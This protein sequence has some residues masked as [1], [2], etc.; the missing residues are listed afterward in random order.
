VGQSASAA[1]STGPV[2]AGIHVN[3]VD[4]LSAD[5]INGVDVSSMIAEEASGV[6]F[7][8]Q[9]GNVADLFDVLADAGVTTVR[10]RVWNDPYDADGNGY[11]GGTNDVAAA[12]EMG[13]RATAAGL[14]V[15]V[16]FHY[17]DFWAD[18]GKQRS[19]KAWE[20]LAI[21]DR[22]DAVES[23][24]ADVLQQ[25]K[26][27]GV[28]VSMVQV[29]NETNSG[30][31]GVT[32]WD[33]MAAIFSAGSAAVRTVFPSA[34][35]V[36]HFTNPETVGRYAG[37]AAELD[38]RGVDY[39][40]FASSYYPYW[41]GSLSHLTSVLS[42]VAATY[43][44]EVMV[45]E[46]SWAYTLE[47]GDGHENTIKAASDA[48]QYPVSV[49]GQATAV[50]DVIQAVSDV[51]DGKG[52]GV[53]Y[54]EPAWIPV[55]PASEL[56]AN[57]VLW[58]ADGSGWA[59]SFAGD[60]DADASTWYGGSSWDNQA[61]FDFAGNPLE[62]LNVFSY[63]RTGAVAPLEVTGVETVTL[64]VTAG[65][66]IAL[67]ATVT[68]SY[69]DSTTAQQAVTWSDA[70]TWI[71]GPGV[72]T[73]SGITSGGYAT[74]ATITVSAPSSLV[75]GDFETGDVTPW[76]LTATTW[77]STF[78]IG[79]SAGNNANGTYAIN[80]YGSSAF[81]FNLAQ[82]VTGLAPGDYVLTG[83]VH[84]QDAAPTDAAMS[85]FA[86]TSAGT[87]TVLYALN[88]WQ[89]WSTPQI[90]VTVPAD[91]AVTVGASG[92]GG[93]ADWAWFDDFSLV[94]YEAAVVDTSALEA[95]LAVAE[96]ISRA[97]YTPESL[98]VLDG[99]IEIAH[100][101]LGASAPVQALVDD[102]VGV[103]DGAFATLVLVGDAPDPT[104]VPVTLTVVEGGTISLPAQ[105]TVK[106][107]NGSATLEGVTWSNSATWIGGPGVYTVTGITS[108]GWQATA[109]VT[110]TVKNWLVNGDFETGDPAP[111]SLTA[112]A[113]PATFWTAS[114][115]GNS[116]HGTWAVSYYSSAG[117]DLNL[118]QTVS[119]LPEGA[120]QFSGQA[121]GEDVGTADT[122][123]TLVGASSTDSQNAAFVLAGWQ[124]WNSQSVAVQVGP[125]GTFTASVEGVGGAEDWGWIDDLTL[126]RVSS[127]AVDTLA[128]ETLLAQ[129]E[130]ADTS[131]A[132]ASAMA[133]LAEAIEAAHVVLAATRP[134]QPAIDGVTA[135]LQSAIDGLAPAVPASVTLSA[136]T[137][138][139]GST[140]TVQIAGV[141]ES[142]V[143]VGVASRFIRLATVTLDG[144]SGTAVITIPS[145]LRPGVHYVQVRNLAGDVL[146]QEA[147]TVLAG[148]G[149]P[150]AHHPGWGW[151]GREHCS[152][153]Q[154]HH[155]GVEVASWGSD[156]RNWGALRTRS[157]R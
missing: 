83:S 57:K 124:V 3:K 26:D 53:F 32:G 80:A 50:R 155:P 1:D 129:A 40:V 117:F 118:S 92:V 125:D 153:Y 62:S 84:G 144:G 141:N 113:W 37:Y 17:S 12:V 152:P 21:G 93:A 114:S 107:Y 94:P 74:S 86:T 146:V 101:V 66:P 46:T 133:A 106:A 99:A 69:N 76:N 19:P 45:A 13:E 63:A 112:T 82:S 7:R 136:T 116:A 100:V 139:T 98:A 20:G 6:V 27:A 89:Q 39:D 138:R 119:G 85:L 33:G 29:G 35:V 73:V 30:V 127:G 68:V 140:I 78:W 143:E 120:Y 15:L 52:I 5:F 96:G 24:S 56:E 9:A 142:Q 70:A 58:E 154:R 97:A 88:G 11:G 59:S 43:G 54:W 103:L 121:H 135:L 16:D 51:P 60:Y 157:R 31:A 48:T 131:G 81:D 8:D 64:S 108:G 23:F 36:V 2:D 126:V 137:V 148:H 67:P 38:A 111:W 61:L 109:T 156:H 49:Q 147:I 128:L 110:V 95:S 130:A 104:V 14:D 44:K 149:H 10:V 91:G 123:L 134:E 18:P 55:G 42:D 87:Q 145:R 150:G 22:A 79:A 151:G 4:G 132:S 90:V 115:A 28:D 41:H 122:T 102:A 34:K 75:N 72:Y 65:D 105:V 47:D 71:S 25:L 77:P